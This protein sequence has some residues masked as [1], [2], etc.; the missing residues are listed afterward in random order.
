[1]PRARLIRVL[2]VVT[3]AVLIAAP[4]PAGAKAA[5][6]MYVY[7]Y[8]VYPADQPFH[9]E[10]ADAITK[11]A[12]EVQDWYEE[13]A[14][15]EFH[16]K[17][18]TVVKSQ[19][20]YVTMRC[21]PEPRNPECV[22]DRQ[23]L[24]NWWQAQQKAT[25]GFLDNRIAW[26]FGQGGG[27]FAG[28]NLIGHWA[29]F[30]LLGDWTLEPISGVVEPAGI[31]CSLADWQCQGGAP[32]GAAAHELGH[33][34]GLHHPDCYPDPARSLMGWHGDFPNDI[35]FPWEIN[36]L[37][38]NPYMRRNVWK[39]GGPW[40]DFGNTDSMF[41]G[42]TQY[43][44]GEGFKRGDKLEFTDANHSIIRTPKILTNGV[45]Q[46]R[47]PRQMGPGFMRLV[48]SKQIRSNLLPVNFYEH[49]FGPGC[50]PLS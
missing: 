38:N 40:L 45:L 3:T 13:H 28:S 14:G 33:A 25:G 5:P 6:R 34:F 48:R 47:I 46:V 19:D 24:D 31:P 44:G 43:V 42:E 15:V 22:N 10:Y 27:G 41:W 7:P 50:A 35:L 17:P 29:G 26:V 23:R 9:Q 21:G 30:S 11:L 4:A 49:R 12:D 8:Y 1:M 36:N 16:Y 37:R 18:L 2:L 39:P 32:K 20:D